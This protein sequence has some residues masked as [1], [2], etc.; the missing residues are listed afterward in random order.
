MNFRPKK[1]PRITLTSTFFTILPILAFILYVSLSSSTVRAA[2]GVEITIPAGAVDA[3]TIDRGGQASYTIL[4]TNDSTGSLTI[5]LTGTNSP[6]NG[7]ITVIP[8]SMTLNANTSQQATVVIVPPSTTAHETLYTSSV[9]AQATTGAGTDTQQLLTTVVEPGQLGVD[10]NG[11]AL[12]RTGTP[13]ST[14]T[15]QHTVQ[16]TGSAQE[17]FD[18]AVISA[19]G[20]STSITGGNTVT[21][22]GNSSAT[23]RGSVGSPG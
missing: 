23:V 10:I 19:Q 4:V 16:N 12:S 21:I 1:S 5:N 11:N 3:Q 22:N 7:T 8:A 18:L 20:F 15:F 14:V 13:G 2:G 6:N 17:T 9:V